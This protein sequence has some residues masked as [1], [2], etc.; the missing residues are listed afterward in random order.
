MD[1]IE[2]AP[3]ALHGGSELHRLAALSVRELAGMLTAC[4]EEAD[5]GAVEARGAASAFGAAHGPA[6]ARLADAAEQAAQN[7]ATSAGV[8]AETDE[9]AIQAHWW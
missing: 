5:E 1:R 3:G 7:L 2:V 4:S 8:Y 6:M 9:R